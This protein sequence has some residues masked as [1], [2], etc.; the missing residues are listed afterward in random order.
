MPRLAMLLLLPL[1]PFPLV[2]PAAL[3]SLCSV[4][5]P[6]LPIN[7]STTLYR[8]RLPQPATIPPSIHFSH[9]RPHSGPPLPTF[10]VRTA[11][12]FQSDG[13]AGCSDMGRFAFVRSISKCLGSCLERDGLRTGE[14]QRSC[15]SVNERDKAQKQTFMAETSESLGFSRRGAW[16]LGIPSCGSFLRSPGKVDRT[17]WTV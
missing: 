9:P 11:M 4:C 13:F 6:L 12:L 17:C 10:T 1:F 2:S 7:P 8:R 15:G 14:S 3:S 16:T 5:L